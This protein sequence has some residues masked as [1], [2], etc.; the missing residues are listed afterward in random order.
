MSKHP[1]LLLHGFTGGPFELQPLADYLEAYGKPCE[2][3]RLPYHGE[4][5]HNLK[6]SHWTNWV[7]SAEGIAGQMTREHGGFDLIGFSM[8]G[9]LAAYL[10][11]RYPVRRLVLLN[12]AVVYVSPARF[13]KVIQEDWLDG[14]LIPLSKMKSTPLRATWQFTRLVRHLK[15]EIA[16][17][18]VPTFI[19]QS[20][21]DQVIHPHSA[22]YIYK[23][24]GGQRELKWY[25]NSK[26]LICLGKDASELFRE[27]E[28]FLDKD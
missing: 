20:K 24:I 22:T 7:S 14:E 9:L 17:V 10:A 23:K 5:R 6:H 2:V 21:M 4:M 16:Q 1:C 18:K 13:I 15:P 25:P 8:G 26:H 28:I 12:T 19:G 3:P 27:V 11:V